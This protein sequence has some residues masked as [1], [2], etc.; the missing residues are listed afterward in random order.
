[1]V[2]TRELEKYL[3]EKSAKDGDIV[4]ICGEGE[5]TEGQFG[6]MLNIPVKC[7]GLDLVWTPS[8]K[9]RN[10]LNMKLKTTD[11][12]NWVGRK[13]QVVIMEDK[14]K[15]ILLPGNLVN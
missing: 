9:A 8:V 11:T 12:K 10:T 7:N 4:E 5:I 15:Q 13:F 2:D 14:G 3:N 6:K 1:M